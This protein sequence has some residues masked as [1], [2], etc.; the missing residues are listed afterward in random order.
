MYQTIWLLGN[1][2]TCILVFEPALN[3]V[4]KWEMLAQIPMAVAVVRFLNGH[5]SFKLNLAIWQY[6][7]IMMTTIGKEILWKYTIQSMKIANSVW[8]SLL[9]RNNGRWDILHAACSG[10]NVTLVPNKSVEHYSPKGPD[11]V[12]S[13]LKALKQRKALRSPNMNYTEMHGMPRIHAFLHQTYCTVWE[14][15]ISSEALLVFISTWLIKRCR[16]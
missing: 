11:N 16:N 12:K 10:L 6:I 14:L 8:L 13:V 9:M 1:V 7:S 5:V 3:F 2:K 15:T 4:E